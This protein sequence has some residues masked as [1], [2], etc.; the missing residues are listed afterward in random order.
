VR[1]SR[2]RGARGKA[3]LFACTLLL[4]LAWAVA[5]AAG[6]L[7]GEPLSA[8]VLRILGA[9][10]GFVFFVR[11]PPAPVRWPPPL[12]FGVNVLTGAL[13]LFGPLAR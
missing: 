8:V 4:F 5:P 10:G 7:A 6:G 1:S 13:E 9:G 11:Y 12:V 3:A 2:P